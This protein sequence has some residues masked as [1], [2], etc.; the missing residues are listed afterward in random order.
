LCRTTVRILPSP[1]NTAKA[2]IR[3]Q[4]ATAGDDHCRSLAQQIA[5][6]GEPEPMSIAAVLTAQIGGFAL[7]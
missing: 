6:I 7:A 5:L 1:N 4:A 2:S 3:L